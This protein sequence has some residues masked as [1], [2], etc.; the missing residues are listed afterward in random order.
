MENIL[1]TIK[2]EKLLKS[3]E[4]VGVATSGG[5]DSMALLHF[6]WSHRAELDIDVCAVHIDHALRENSGEDA[7]FVMDFCKQNGIRAYKFRVDVPKLMEQKKLTVEEG[8][9]EA[10]FGVFEALHRKNVVDKIA[11][12]HNQKDQAETILLNLFRGTGSK[13]ASGMNAQ[14]DGLYIRPMLATPKQKILDYIFLND[15]PYITDQTNADNAFSRN[16]I[17]NQILPLIEERWPNVVERLV[18]FGKDCS[19][20]DD[21]ITSLVV[22]D[23][24]IYED[25]T[26]MIPLSYFLYPNP[27]VS[28]MLFVVLEKI[29]VTADIE[30]VHIEMIKALDKT[31]DNGK[32]LKLPNKLMAFKEYDYITLTNK[33]KN[34]VEFSANWGLGETDVNGFGSIIVRRTQK[35]EHKE[36]EL[37]LDSAKVP[38]DA[39]WRFKERGDLFEKFGGGTKKLKDFLIDRKIPSR[40]RENLPV[41]ASGKNVLAVAGVEI[42]N[43]VRVDNN[44]KQMYKI[45][46]KKC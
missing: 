29:G 43:S 25:Q 28:K 31:S 37:V 41:L 11:I 46:T 42:S 30:R 13:G 19:E 40:L 14:R 8:A 15:I 35:L 5:S 10:R 18:N 7:N 39:V 22:D 27:V 2:T 32:K 26:A 21:Y 20:N 44:T 6:L 17:R 9:R 1:Q 24:V 3:G 23:A 4:V 45:I 16:F 34:K 36:G 12:A 38:K 33:Q